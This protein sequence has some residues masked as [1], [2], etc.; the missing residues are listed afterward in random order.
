M[1]E[2]PKVFDC[3]TFFNELDLLELRLNELGS[4]VDHFVIVEARQTFTGNPKPLFFA[5]NKE[6]FAQFLTKIIHVVVETFPSGNSS[7]ER[8]I[9]QR[10]R[11]RDGLVAARPDDLLLLSDIDEIPRASALAEV[12]ANPPARNEVV[13]FELDWHAFYLN[14]RL[15]EKWVR[16]GPRLVRVG[17]LVTINGLRGVYAPTP[18]RSRDAVRWLK[19]CRRMKTLVRRRVIPDAGWHFS[20]LGGV[21]AVALKGSSVSEHSH[22][23]KGDKSADWARQ[24][25]EGQLG[26]RQTYD[27]VD[28]DDR[29]PL[30]VRQ[31][32]DMFDQYHLMDVAVRQM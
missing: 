28:I 21:E 13:C 7:W 6:R 22:L 20:W 15:R 27:I 26:A 23:P 11:V 17:S 5:E 16:L 10:D 2:Q 32:P 19:A 24:R 18:E 3:F 25:I 14:V 4:V 31:R 1:S 9:Y 30:F 12:K 8:E 29:F